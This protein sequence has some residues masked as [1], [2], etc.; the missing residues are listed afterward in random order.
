MSVLKKIMVPVI[1]TLIVLAGLTAGAYFLLKGSGEDKSEFDVRRRDEQSDQ[2]DEHAYRYDTDQLAIELVREG[3]RKNVLNFEDGDIFSVDHSKDAAERLYRLKR[4]MNP[5]FE[6][7]LIAY[8]P[9]G[10]SPNTY[11]FYFKTTGRCMIKYTVTVADEK[12]PDHIRYVNNGEPKNLT[13]EHEFAVGGLVPG[14]TNYIILDM[15]D[16]TGSHRQDITYKVDVPEAPQLSSLHT[17]R[18]KSGL[19]L[20]NGLFFVMPKND[21]QIYLYDNIGNLRG[22]MATESGHGSR[23]FQTDDNLTYMV[24]PKKVAR[25]TPLGEVDGIAVFDTDAEIIDISYDGFNNVFALVTEKNGYSILR[26]S[27]EGGPTTSIY[28]FDKGVIP[29]SISDVSAGNLYISTSSPAGIMRLDGLIS[30]KPRVGLVIG[31]KSEWK[32]TSVKK[33]VKD[34]TVTPK[35]SEDEEKD[36][37]GSD[38]DGDA[39]QTGDAEE[40]TPETKA[41]DDEGEDDEADKEADKETEEGE[42]DGSDDDTSTSEII[43]LDGWDMENTLLTLTKDESDGV[44]DTLTFTVKKDRV[45]HAIKLFIDGKNKKKPATVLFD[46]ETEFDGKVTAAW[47]DRGSSVIVNKT[48]GRYEERDEDFKVTKSFAFSSELDGVWKYSLDKMCF[49]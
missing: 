8:N 41:A 25:I 12:I 13:M 23:I 40:D 10:T 37:E 30:Q 45:I 21:K 34:P 38:A 9:F 43:P 1:L 36:A 44:R 16:E 35:P 20:Q 14:M 15:L 46:K 29:T 26:A 39:S 3:D 42:A 47:G 33:K 18:G 6:E 32:K 17:E 11:Y 27:M 4:R 48:R 7:P 19:R 2:L 31:I 28:K 24:S 22:I 49:Y 5:T